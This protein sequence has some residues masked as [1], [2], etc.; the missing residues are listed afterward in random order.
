MGC[1]TA[2]SQTS[3]KSHS[4]SFQFPISRLAAHF[5]SQLIASKR[6]RIATKKASIKCGLYCRRS[7]SANRLLAATLTAKWSWVCKGGRGCRVSSMILCMEYAPKG[8]AKAKWSEVGGCCSTQVR[9]TG[10][11]GW[12]AGAKGK[13]SH[14]RNCVSGMQ[15]SQAAKPGTHWLT[16]SGVARKCQTA[17]AGAGSSHWPLMTILGGGWLLGQPGVGGRALNG[18]SNFN[19]SP[20]T[21]VLSAIR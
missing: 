19:H 13:R 9:V 4:K 2:S 12:A 20:T 16:C 21:F 18:A 14:S 10:S 6:W 7:C 1:Q 15:H 17:W 11:G 3:L 5:F 8:A